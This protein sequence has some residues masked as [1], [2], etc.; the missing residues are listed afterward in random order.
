MIT[1]TLLML[2]QSPLQLKAEVNLRRAS[3]LPLSSRSSCSDPSQPSITIITT[4]EVAIE[5][6]KDPKR[7]TETEIAEGET[8]T[9]TENRVRSKPLSVTYVSLRVG[10]VWLADYWS[11]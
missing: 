9:G 10:A 2:S 7:D 5:I 1:R 6:P 3:P 11:S 4:I 8:S